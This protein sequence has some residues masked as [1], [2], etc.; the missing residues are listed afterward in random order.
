MLDKVC[1]SPLVV[2]VQ[3]LDALLKIGTSSMQPLVWSRIQNSLSSFNV[4]THASS[5]MS[6]QAVPLLSTLKHQG[7]LTSVFKSILLFPT[8]QGRRL[9]K[10]PKY[11]TSDRMKCQKKNKKALN[12]KLKFLLPRFDFA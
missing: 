11:N 5:A 10:I 9:D 8:W 2:V 1:L 12:L 3:L 7:C 6:F 4:R